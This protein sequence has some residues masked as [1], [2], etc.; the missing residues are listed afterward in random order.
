VNDTTTQ[1]PADPGMARFDAVL[2]QGTALE[3]TGLD[4]RQAWTTFNRD[5]RLRGCANR[6]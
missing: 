2:P 1:T 4:G 3:L 6:E 5:R